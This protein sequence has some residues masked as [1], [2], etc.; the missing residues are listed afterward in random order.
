MGMK[1][2]LV[3]EVTSLTSF[4]TNAGGLLEKIKKTR[5]PLFLTQRGRPV[6]ILDDVKGYGNRLERLELLEAIVW[7]LQA[8]ETRDVVSHQEAMRRL[9]EFLND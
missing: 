7:G 8:A 6:A 2:H 4:F 3:D 1:V 9:D 5:R